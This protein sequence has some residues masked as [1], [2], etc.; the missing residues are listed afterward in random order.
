RAVEFLH[1][2]QESNGG[3]I[4]TGDKIY[5]QQHQ[6]IVRD[7]SQA[8]RSSKIS[9]TLRSIEKRRISGRTSSHRGIAIGVLHP[10]MVRVNRQNCTGLVTGNI[11][12]N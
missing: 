6:S 5:I 7:H 8:S 10:E 4:V 3:L 2:Y 9:D 12:V 11:P 1:K